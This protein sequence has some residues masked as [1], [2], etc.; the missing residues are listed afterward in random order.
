[1]SERADTAYSPRVRE[2]EHSAAASRTATQKLGAANAPSIG[3]D[4]HR[5][6]CGLARLGG[7]SYDVFARRHL[8]GK[9]A[10]PDSLAYGRSVNKPPEPSVGRHFS[11][12]ADYA[13][14]KRAGDKME[15]RAILRFHERKS[16]ATLF[17]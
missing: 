15:L 11:D 8:R 3:K 9:C 10:A 13:L 6:G 4:C 17:D 2:E 16:W 1:M 5:D 14:L 7:A 12:L